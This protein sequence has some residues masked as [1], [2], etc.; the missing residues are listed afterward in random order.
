MA[1]RQSDSINDSHARSIEIATCRTNYRD[2][3]DITAIKLNVGQTRG[4]V[5]FDS[6]LD[7]NRPVCIARITMFR[8][9]YPDYGPI[10]TKTRR[11]HEIIN[12]EQEV[13]GSLLPLPFETE[14]SVAENNYAGPR[15]LSAFQLELLLSRLC[16]FICCC[17]SSANFLIEIH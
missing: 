11:F 8:F 17:E 7:R 4:Q 16:S 9:V 12:R 3:L 2:I 6:C 5:I 10:V 1:S 14:E 13:H 15:N